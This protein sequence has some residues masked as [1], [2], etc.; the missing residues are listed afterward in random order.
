MW[1]FTGFYGTPYAHDREDSWGV[2]KNLFNGNNIPWLICGDFNEVMCSFENKG[3]LPR[4]EKRMEL[5]RK[6]LEFCQL[7]DV[8]YLG[9]WFTWEKGNLPETNIRERLVRGWRTRS[10]FHFSLKSKLNIWFTRFRIT[11][12]KMAI[13]NFLQKM[14]FLKKGLE[15]WATDIRNTKTGK[16]EISRGKAIIV[17]RG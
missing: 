15:S 16:K 1:R 17:A 3:G 12:W 2:L 6:A 10:G 11:V 5:F 7:N 13:G 9:R 14:E 8:G 4:D